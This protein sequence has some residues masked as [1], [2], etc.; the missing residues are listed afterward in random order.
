M[1]IEYIVHAEAG[2]YWAE[3]PA[4]PGCV[5]DGRTLAEVRANIREAAQGAIESY[6]MLPPGADPGA[7]APSEP[8]GRMGSFQLRFARPRRCRAAAMA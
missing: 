3:V 6:A 1:R 4:I 7:P 5:T 2:G 8:G